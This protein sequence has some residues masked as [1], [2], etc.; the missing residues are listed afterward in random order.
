MTFVTSQLHCHWLC[1]NIAFFTFVQPLNVNMILFC[2]KSLALKFIKYPRILI[3]FYMGD[4]YLDFYENAKST[5]LYFP[6]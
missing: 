1:R 5:T 3:L 2:N 6:Y 4:I